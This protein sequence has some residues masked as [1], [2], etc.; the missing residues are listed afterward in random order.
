[1]SVNRERYFEPDGTAKPEALSTDPWLRILYGAEDYYW[2]PERIGKMAET[3]E[4]KA[5]EYVL[6]TLDILDEHTEL[7]DEQY[8]LLRTVLCW[9]E[10]AKGGTKKERDAWRKRGYPLEIHNEA[11]AM[12]YADHCFV[13]D[14]VTDPACILIRTHGLAGQFVR[15][16]C[17]MASS[18]DLSRIAETMTEAEFCTLITVLNEC[19]IRAVDETIWTDV[20][21]KIRQFAGYIHA[22]IFR[23]YFAPERLRRLLPKAK[24]PSAEDLQIFA[25]RIFPEYDLWYCEAAL[26]PFDIHGAAKICAL[27]ADCAGDDIRHLNFKP[28]ADAL[29]YDYEGRRHINT[30]KQ[31]ILERWLEDPDTYS[32]HV[33]LEFVKQAPFVLI[34]VRF[35]PVC[36]KLISFCVEAE[37]SGLLSYEKSITMLYDM[38]GFRRDAFDRLN[39]E[40]KYLERMNAAQGSTK[41][42]IPDLVTGRILLDVGSGGGILLDELEKRHPECRVIGTDI[43]RNVIETLAE[44]KKKEHHTWDV[45][46]HNFADGPFA[47]TVD[48]V[49]FSSILHEIYSYTETPQGRFNIASVETALTNAAE[50]LNPGGRIVIRDGVKTPGTGKLRIRFRTPEGMEYFLRFKEDFHGMDAIPEEER[51]LN[52]SRETDTVITEINYGREFLYTYTWG[53]S[54]F[55]HECQECFGYYCVDDFVRF[56]ASLGL[57]MIKA[58]SLLEP[59]Y[60]EHLSPLVELSDPDTGEPCPFPDSNC[61][62][63]AEKPA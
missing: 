14:P 51:I 8:R 45:C 38:F 52:I 13:R 5:L 46:V 33:S 23:E 16:E 54:S 30:Y 20:Q 59:G 25:Q 17:R 57:R 31:R 10:C 15:G 11:S 37:R 26:S 41:I 7:P 48:T 39:N 19:I 12:I 55:A 43:S 29:V 35:T 44:K 24:E 22:G 61:I 47:Q 27:A 28:L 6:R 49:I 4:N 21:G 34:G 63:V 56:F 36:E 50:S 40:E 9:S 3:E 42:T 32:Q 1:M 62:I 60:P 18:R 53:A 58:E 2:N